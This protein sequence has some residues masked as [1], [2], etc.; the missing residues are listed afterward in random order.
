MAAFCLIRAMTGKNLPFCTARFVSWPHFAV[1][2]YTPQPPPKP[3]RF[4]K[5]YISRPG[6]VQGL[7][8]RQSRRWFLDLFLLVVKDFEDFLSFS[9][10][11]Q[12]CTLS[13]SE[14]DAVRDV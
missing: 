4:I 9:L 10:H 7:S 2:Q 12:R 1:P 3:R 5:A 8:S 11:D 13:G 14:L 6:H